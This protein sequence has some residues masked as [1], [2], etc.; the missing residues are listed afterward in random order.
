MCLASRTWYSYEHA[1]SEKSACWCRNTLAGYGRRPC[2]RE[3]I[4]FVKEGAPRLSLSMVSVFLI[5]GRRGGKLLSTESGPWHRQLR[6]RKEVDGERGTDTTCLHRGPRKCLAHALPTLGT[7][8]E[9]IPVE[10]WPILC[11]EQ[12]LT[13][14]FHLYFGTD[15]KVDGHKLSR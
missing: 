4:L 2:T 6:D 8:L 10:Q 12:A 11:D 14:A 15:S 7:K 9:N 3:L 1:S 5:G 13:D